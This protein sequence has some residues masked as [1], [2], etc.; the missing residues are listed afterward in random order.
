MLT[1]PMRK[2]SDGQY[3]RFLSRVVEVK[4]SYHSRITNAATRGKA[5]HP[6]IPSQYL[7]DARTSQTHAAAFGPNHKDRIL[8]NGRR[9]GM[10]FPYWLEVYSNRFFPHFKPD[11]TSPQL[12]YDNIQKAVRDP[13]FVLC[14]SARGMSAHGRSKTLGS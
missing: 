6:K 4:A 8:L 2:K 3:Y 5:G 12:H 11:H 13:S 7:F 9:S 1:P 10:Q 14:L